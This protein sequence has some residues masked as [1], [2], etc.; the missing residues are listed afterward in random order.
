ME[1]EVL[2]RIFQFL[3]EKEQ[4]NPPFKWKLLNNIPL[5][6]GNLN[7]EITE[8][9]RYID[10]DYQITVDGYFIQFDGIL[11]K[12]N[13]G[14]SVDYEF[15]PSYFLDPMA[16]KYYDLF[17]EEIEDEILNEFYKM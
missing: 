16:E 2:K 12:Y 13:S 10:V 14:R 3:E 8:S 17:W 4:Q 9:D 11:E 1:K 7:I 15:V 6:K 5:T